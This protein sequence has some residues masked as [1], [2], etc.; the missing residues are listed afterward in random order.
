M[1]FNSF[2][3][4]GKSV[5]NMSID[6]K[7][8][9][10]KQEEEPYALKFVAEEPNATVTIQ[11]RYNSAKT[12]YMQYS[13]DG[14]TWTNFSTSNPKKFTFSNIGDYVYVRARTEDNPSNMKFSS[15]GKYSVYGNIASLV[16]S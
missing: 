13:Y 15:S 1:G 7:V 16:S 8:I 2:Y 10:R 5:K 12:R 9:Y 11:K 6:G 3:I 4:D 14:K